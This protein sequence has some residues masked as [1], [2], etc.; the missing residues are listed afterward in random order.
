MDGLRQNL[1]SEGLK[2]VVYVVI[3]HHGERARHLHSLLAGRLSQHITLYGQDEHQPDVWQTLNGEKEDFLIYD[4]CGRL[5]HR[6]SLP[7]SVIAAGFVESAIK[8][9]YCKHACGEFPPVEEDT[10][11]SRH[12]GQHHG[13]GQHGATHGFHPRGVGHGHNHNHGHDGH[14]GGRG[15]GQSQHS[16]RHQ[17]QDGGVSQRQH[18]L[19]LGQL[20]EVMNM[21]QLQQEADGAAA[22]P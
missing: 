18:H 12:H 1:Q 2:D 20:Q 7:Y 19:D 9:A 10:E 6:I 16:A 4:R 5:T 11:H 17:G 15:Q 3:N 21:H 13:H 14:G 8:E 22:R